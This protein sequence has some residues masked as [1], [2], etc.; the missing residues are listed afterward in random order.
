M[1]GLEVP[2][3]T[4]GCLQDIH[5]SMG[6]F[7]YFPTYSLGNLNSAQLFASAQKSLGINLGT[8]QN[9]NYKSLLDWLRT[10]VHQYG[11][12]HTP[13]QLMQQAT[14]QS[15]K[16]NYHWTYLKDRFASISKV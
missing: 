9:G 7:G 15:T 2:N 8:L 1:F 14:G 6:G 5:W 13:D 4:Q 3:D 11:K 10:N 12:Q 16:P